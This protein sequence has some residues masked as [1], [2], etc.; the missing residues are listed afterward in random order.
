MAWKGMGRELLF[1]IF[2]LFGFFLLSFSSVGQ[3]LS[4]GSVHAGETDVL[5]GRSSI[6]VPKPKT[7]RSFMLRNSWEVSHLYA[8]V[9][10][11]EKLWV[12]NSSLIHTLYFY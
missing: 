2:F 5:R 9:S 7:V 1:R 10:S 8:S 11:R 3:T 6:D 4:V 12:T